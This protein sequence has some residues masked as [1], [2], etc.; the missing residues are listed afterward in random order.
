VK[1]LAG[2]SSKQRSKHRQDVAVAKDIEKNSFESFLSSI[3]PSLLQ[4]HTDAST[5]CPKARDDGY[6]SVF[7]FRIAASERVVPMVIA[8]LNVA[9]NPAIVAKKLMR[10]LHAVLQNG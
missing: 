4:A 8:T 5:G 1:A 10:L 3:L 9:P 6:Q 2:S 7:F